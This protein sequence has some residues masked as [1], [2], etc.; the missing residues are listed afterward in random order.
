MTGTEL[1][2]FLRDTSMLCRASGQS[3]VSLLL[4]FAAFAAETAGTCVFD[5]ADAAQSLRHAAQR[6]RIA[7]EVL[8]AAERAWTDRFGEVR[9]DDEFTDQHSVPQGRG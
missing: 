3:D 9:E 1:S 7:P 8:R 4:T 6:Y 2:D 5:T